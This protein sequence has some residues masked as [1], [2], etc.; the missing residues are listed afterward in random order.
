MVKNTGN[1][2]SITNKYPATRDESPL[3]MNPYT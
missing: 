1:N 3:Q 2:G